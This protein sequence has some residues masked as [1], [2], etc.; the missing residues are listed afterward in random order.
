MGAQRWIDLGFMRLQPSELAKIGLVMMLAFYY[1]RLPLNKISHP[2]WVLIPIVITL[3]PTAMVLR[4]P[5]LGTA[6]LLLATGGAVM[7]LAGVHWAYFA[8]VLGGVIALVASVFQ[9]RGTTWQML[10]DYQFRRIDTFLNPA[11]DPLGAGYHITQSK[12]CLLYTSP[13]PRDATLSRMPSSA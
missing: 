4:Q 1:D 3:V 6:L 8:A 7:F 2:L 11:I 9:S 13:S 12:I 10:A 5:D